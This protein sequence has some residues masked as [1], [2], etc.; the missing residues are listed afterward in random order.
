[1]QHVTE[2]RQRFDPVFT[3]NG[4]GDFVG[5]ARMGIADH[6]MRAFLGKAPGCRLPYTGP[7]STRD[8]RHL[9]L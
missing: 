1:M 2:N 6:H 9:I 4:L 5:P 3:G 8:N 7:G